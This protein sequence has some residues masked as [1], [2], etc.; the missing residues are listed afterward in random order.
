[1]YLHLY[2]EISGRSSTTISKLRL[3]A[4]KIG[5]AQKES[6]VGREWS[7]ICYDY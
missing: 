4:K 5:N 7:S 1:M 2:S 3:R 6:S